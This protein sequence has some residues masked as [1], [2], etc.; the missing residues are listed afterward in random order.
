MALGTSTKLGGLVR[1]TESNFGRYVINSPLPVLALFGSR[2]C[3]GSRALR[4]LLQEFAA[5]HA[6]R[7]RFAAINAEEAGLLASQFGLHLTPTLIVALGGEIAARVV[8]FVSP[9]LLRLLCDQVASGALPPEPFWSPVEATF[10]DLVVAP[11]L[12]AWG[13][14][15]VRQAASPAPARGRIDFLVYDDPAAPPLT[16]FENKRQIL[17]PQ[18]LAQAAAQ[19]H[20]YARALGLPS[21]V[22]AAPAGLWIYSSAE[23]LPVAVRRVTSLEL[24]EEPDSVP[25]LLRQLRRL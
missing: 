10:E 4:P 8:G 18:A 20:G 1:V 17:S 19:A 22:V 15:Y 24:Q 5:A 12:D 13:F 11:L 2:A 21:C 9:H 23:R 14:T 16:L 25:K 3:P 7:V 6:G